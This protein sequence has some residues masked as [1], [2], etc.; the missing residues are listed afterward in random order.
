[1]GYSLSGAKHAYRKASLMGLLWYAERW[2]N[3]TVKD[4]L[5]SFSPIDKR[6]LDRS[7]DLLERRMAEESDLE[8]VLDTAGYTVA[9][10]DV[11]DPDEYADRISKPYKGT[12]YHHGKYRGFGNYAMLGLL[13]ERQSIRALAEAVGERDPAVVVEIGSKSGGS[14]YVWSRYFDTATCIVSIDLNY[15]G[16]RD[17]FFQAFAPETEIHCIHGDSSDS[18]T[19]E[20]LRDVLGD[21]TIDFLYIDGDHTYSGVKRDFETYTKLVDPDGVVGL[22]DISDPGWE[23]IDYWP[24]LVD[25]YDTRELGGSIFKNGLVEL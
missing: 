12:A 19:F 5:T 11:V 3:S 14:L 15:P 13:Q 21:R 9:D 22:H 4:A 24:E 2:A 16:R 7:I 6:C 17:E 8:D 1:M 20:Q 18:E 25:A 10:H 23:V